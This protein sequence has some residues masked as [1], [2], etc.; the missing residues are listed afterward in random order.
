VLV[1]LFT[2]STLKY[3]YYPNWDIA[4]ILFLLT[5]LAC[6]LAVGYNVLISSRANDVR[7]AQQLGTLIILPFGAVNLLSEFKVLTLT[8]N[9][10]LIMGAILAV[11][12]VIIFFLVKATFHREEIPPKWK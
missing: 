3:L 5:P 1:D 8:T 6:I 11:I 7:T 9:N 10:L 4:I 2:Y 12:D